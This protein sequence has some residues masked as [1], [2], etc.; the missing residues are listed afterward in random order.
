M[1]SKTIIGGD[2][3]GLAKY[4]FKGEGISEVL[5]AQGVRSESALM[6]AHDF[7]A[8]C[9]ANGRSSKAKRVWHSSLS[10]SPRDVMNKERMTEAGQHFAQKMGLSNS[11]YA[12][13]AHFDKNHYSH[14]HIIC[15]RIDFNG[16]L[17]SDN[18]TALR[19]KSACR[20]IEKEMGLE[21]FELTYRPNSK[22]SQELRREQ[23]EISAIV[24][25]KSDE[26][27]AETEQSHIPLLDVPHI[28]KDDDY[29]PFNPYK[30]KKR[31]KNADLNR[32]I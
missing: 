24:F 25:L 13:I 26:H 17:I 32:L 2:F 16:S 10:F 21:S 23:T 6:I 14:I 4:L 5:F 20:E 8:H 31:G 30:K 3:L 29:L 19:G 18:H 9:N 15:N 11:Q 28:A 12:I 22:L 7:E 1:I 27:K